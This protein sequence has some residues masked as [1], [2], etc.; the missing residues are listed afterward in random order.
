MAK[1][2]LVIEYYNGGIGDSE[3]EGLKG[4]FYF[5]KNL[6]IFS[7]P[8]NISLLPET[9][10]ESSTT[11]VDL[12]KWIVP[13]TPHD[14][15]TYA[16]GDTGKLYQRTSAGS[17]SVIRTVSNC[18]GQGLELHNDYLY[19]TQ[20]TQIGRYGLLSG[21][22]SF[23]DN[24]QTGLNNTSTHKFAPIKAFLNGFA[25]GHGNKLAW[26]DGSVWTLA[27]LTLPAGFNIRSLEVIDEYLAIGT[28]VGTSIT[29][30]ESG[31]VFFWDG[32]STTF[33]FF[34]QIPEGGVNALLNSRNRLLTIAGSNG[35]IYLN[36]N[37][38]QKVHKFPKLEYSKNVEVYPGGVTNWKGLANLG[39]AGS[40][41]ST[42]IEQGVYEWGAK[43]D[44][45]NEALNFGYT[46]STGTTQSTTMQIGAVKGIGSLMLVGWRDGS[47][48]GVDKVVQTADAFATG[49]YES[50]IF[51]DKRPYQDKLAI[52]LK[53]THKAL[54]SGESVQLGYKVNRAAAYTT[55]TANSTVGSTET[56]LPLP[57]SGARFK[58]FQF[59]AIPATSAA[60]SPTITSLALEYD[61]LTEE[62]GGF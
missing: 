50:L 56:R 7:E 38:F 61:D 33:N 30:S 12:V 59:E 54:V 43:S 52:T 44:K 45:Y 19:Y 60:T 24:W 13:G 11:V 27:K 23:T 37:P 28:W 14:T 48:Y 1:K 2:I 29:A 40:T 9:A 62:L 5:A 18:V 34:V 57:A 47:T 4:A 46:I 39:V 58:E 41:D 21:S 17:W 22:P 15:N 31:Y 8:T 10:K 36:T 26:W 6:N 25:V 49:V 3:K 35:F 16:L 55:G 20:N 53:A 32:T 42:S 51:D